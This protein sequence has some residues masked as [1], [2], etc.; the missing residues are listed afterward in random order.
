VRVF[1]QRAEAAKW[2]GVPVEL[3][4]AKPVGGGD[5]ASNHPE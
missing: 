4:A 5:Q 1:Q 3:L 2:L